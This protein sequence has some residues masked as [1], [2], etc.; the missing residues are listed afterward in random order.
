M[1]IHGSQVERRRSQ[2]RKCTNL[3]FCNPTDIERI[4]A[5]EFRYWL[6]Q[7]VVN[8]APR[9]ISSCTFAVSPSFAYCNNILPKSITDIVDADFITPPITLFMSICE[10][11]KDHS[12]SMSYR[13]I[14]QIYTQEWGYAIR[15]RTSGSIRSTYRCC[16]FYKH[17]PSGE[18]WH[19]HWYYLS[20]LSPVSDRQWFSP[21]FAVSGTRTEASNVEMP[22]SDFVCLPLEVQREYAFGY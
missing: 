16:L 2:L 1:I 6:T 14:T 3:I 22:I 8:G 13:S 18:H 11:W 7:S 19:P 10:Y 15:C 17:S 12:L 20:I 9:L 5:F 4:S 21:L